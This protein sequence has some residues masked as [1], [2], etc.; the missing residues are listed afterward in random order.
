[1]FQSLGL[2]ASSILIDIADKR[3]GERET[4]FANSSGATPRL[5]YDGRWGKGGKASATTA[6]LPSR[7]INQGGRNALIGKRLKS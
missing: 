3:F 1:M 6:R 7:S 5:A 4:A 2:L